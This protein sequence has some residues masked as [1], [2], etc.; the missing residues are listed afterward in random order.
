MIDMR[1]IKTYYA[2]FTK[3]VPIL[4]HTYQHVDCPDCNIQCESPLIFSLR[5]LERKR[6]ATW[7]GLRDKLNE[8]VSQYD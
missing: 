4:H 7:W 2:N 8:M 6:T 5:T 1:I 3:F